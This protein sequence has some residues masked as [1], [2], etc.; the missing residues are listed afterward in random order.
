[1]Q[2]LG[3]LQGGVWLGLR[4]M[5]QSLSEALLILSRHAQQAVLLDGAYGKPPYR[6]GKSP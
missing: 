6:S 4:W 1:M 5:H 2:S 3:L